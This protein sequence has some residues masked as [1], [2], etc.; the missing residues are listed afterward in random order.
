MFT[1]KT[2]IDV[3]VCI[4]SYDE[5]YEAFNSL[6][7]TSRFDI[8]R[9]DVTWLSWFAQKLLRPLSEI[10]ENIENSL[11]QY[12]EGV[13]E[14]YCRVHGQIYALPVTPSV[15][16]LYYRKDLFESPICKRTY[17]EQFHEELQPPKTFEKYNRIAAFFT[18]DLSPSSPVPYGSTI[19]LGSTGV[20][21][22][23]FL[24][25][26]FAIQENLYGAD[27]Q[28]RLDSPACQQA[29]TELVELRRC[30]SPEYCGWW[31]Q[32]ARRFAEGNFAMS[33]LYSNYASDLSAHS[34]RVVGNVGYS[35]M[36]GNNPVLGGGSLGVSKY[37]KRPK[38]ALSFIKW[39]CS[40]PLCS[41]SAL[42][43]STSPC[44][45]TYD[46]YEV[47]HNYPWLKLS[48]HCFPIAKGNRLPAELSVPFDERKF[49]SILGLAVKNAYTGIV[50]PKEAL[51]DAQMQFS[52]YFHTPLGKL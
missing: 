46:N 7:E 32:T 40:E 29:L 28:I 19:T 18:R 36:P 39:M 33:I 5:I 8:L 16:I 12:V 37:C 27:G 4:L 22:S 45:R 1:Q 41:A 44:R 38:D 23:E 52:N 20:A 31:T 35:M 30:T 48:R 26:L 10:D 17:F 14:H 9:L 34:S 6:D 3:N 47:L 2:G 50:T 49:L 13:P 42:L 43:G 51:S 21:G 11:G 25:R 15:Q 24:A